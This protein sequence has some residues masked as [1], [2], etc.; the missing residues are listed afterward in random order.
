LDGVLYLGVAVRLVGARPLRSAVFPRRVVA[1]VA[2]VLRRVGAVRPAGALL[3]LRRA[4]AVRPVGVAVPLLR[5]CA[6]PP[7]HVLLPA[8]RPVLRARLPQCLA[9]P[10]ARP[11]AS[12]WPWRNAAHDPRPA[13]APVRR[14]WRM[15]SAL[16]V[17]GRD[18]LG[19]ASNTPSS[20]RG[21]WR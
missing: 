19:R 8:G 9:A 14:R 20:L 4:C 13:R 10:V 2:G 17:D 11:A 5:A 3:L 6:V 18:A 21:R 16:A 1:L 15:E 7:V 12:R